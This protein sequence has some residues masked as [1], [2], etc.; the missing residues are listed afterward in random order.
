MPSTFPSLSVGVLVIFLH[1]ASVLRRSPFAT[2]TH[3][4]PSDSEREW[5]YILFRLLLMPTPL[6]ISSPPVAAPFL[7]EDLPL[8]H[9]PWRGCFPARGGVGV[10]VVGG[11]SA[12]E[13]VALGQ[14]GGMTH[15]GSP[16]FARNPTLT[17]RSPEQN[18]SLIPIYASRSLHS[19]Q[20][21]PWA[22]LRVPILLADSLPSVVDRCKVKTR[23]ASNIGGAEEEL[24]L[25][26]NETVTGHGGED[27]DTVHSVKLAPWWDRQRKLHFDSSSVPKR[28]DDVDPPSCT[29]H[30]QPIS[31]TPAQR[32]PSRSTR[33]LSLFPLWVHVR[34]P[35]LILRPRGSACVRALAGVAVLI[36]HTLYS[37]QMGIFPNTPFATRTSLLC[38]CP[39]WGV[40]GETLTLQGVA[41]VAASQLRSRWW[42]CSW[43][44]RSEV[45]EVPADENVVENEPPYAAEMKV[46]RS[47]GGCTDRQEKVHRSVIAEGGY[48]AAYGVVNVVTVRLKDVF[49]GYR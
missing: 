11:G 7:G 42:S 46:A 32:R 21:S 30:S 39:R 26:A 35:L 29:T 23:G 4:P 34:Y 49:C 44:R 36:T 3:S 48:V 37:V 1:Q 5:N 13:L 33:D 12:Y 43:W 18:S 17:L 45:E 19:P 25:W 2:A 8:P 14:S 24:G 16:P 15:L 9:P 20:T 27:A 47:S 41:K 22:A 10:G 28:F 38:L 31:S 6:P 40:I